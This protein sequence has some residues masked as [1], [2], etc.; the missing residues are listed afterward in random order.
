MPKLIVK[1]KVA[2]PVLRSDEKKYITYDVVNNKATKSTI[3]EFKLPKNVNDVDNYA[4]YGLHYNNS[5]LKTVNLSSLEN[6]SGAY[7]LGN[8]FQSCASLESADLSNLESIT[9]QYALSSTFYGSS[10]E[11]IDLSSLSVVGY[12]ALQSAFYNCQRLTS[13]DLSALTS[14]GEYGLPSTFNQCYNLTSIDLSS[15]T[16]IGNYGLESA[17]NYCNNLRYFILNNLSLLNNDY[18]FSSAFAYA[19]E[20]F[21]SIDLKCIEQITGNY[22]FQSAF[23]NC[24][25]LETIDFSGLQTITG[26]Y[27][28]QNMCYQCSKLKNIYFNNLE[29]I[30]SSPNNHTFYCAFQYCTDL[31]RVD[32]PKLSS[33]GINITGTDEN[34]NPFYGC[35][36]CCNGITELH[37]HH[38]MQQYSQYLTKE[39]LFGGTDSS[40]CHPN[41]QILF[42]LGL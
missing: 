23:Y 1:N 20:N 9:G 42:D 17:F 2:V 3:T 4:L 35:F 30:P 31:E 12:Y 7:A 14:I 22:N 37:F 6:I 29:S 21:K 38:T 8:A 26:N 34:T 32:F 40:Y 15:L 33:N 36:Y 28:F 5:K 16:S 25:D 11:T 24:H 13:I 27:N 10:I 41:L 18:C 39:C 19:Q